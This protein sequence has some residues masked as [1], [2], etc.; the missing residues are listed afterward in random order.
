MTNKVAPGGAGPCP[1]GMLAVISYEFDTF[2]FHRPKKNCE[3]GFFFCSD[4]DWVINCVENPKG[5]LYSGMTE[6]TTTVAGII[7]R[8]NSLISFHFPIELINKEGNTQ[9]DFEI[10]NVDEDLSFGDLTLVKG[11]YPSTFTNNEII[12][13]V[14]A[15]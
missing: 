9:S 14:P 5:R 15:K 8:E 10:F 11:N 3:S 6:T 1:P 2:R 13:N 4:G 12:I 7:D